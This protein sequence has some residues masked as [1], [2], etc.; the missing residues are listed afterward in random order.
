MAHLFQ[1]IC[2]SST[3]IYVKGYVKGFVNVEKLTD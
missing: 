1:K 3:D 2:N